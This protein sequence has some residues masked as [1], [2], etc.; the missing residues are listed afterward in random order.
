M[1][2]TYQIQNEIN[3]LMVF[4]SKIAREIFSIKQLCEYLSISRVTLN[5]WRN[6]KGLKARNV[7]KRVF[8]LKEDIMEFI[9]KC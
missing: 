6:N 7:G 2:N 5:D 3:D 8:F 4:E 1:V 9:K